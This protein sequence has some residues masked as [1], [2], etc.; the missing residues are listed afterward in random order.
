MSLTHY[1]LL[2]Y[3]NTQQGGRKTLGDCEA[4]AHTGQ[5]TLTKHSL[6]TVSMTVILYLHSCAETENSC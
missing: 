2:P 6:M 1:I 4:R 3:Y 5:E